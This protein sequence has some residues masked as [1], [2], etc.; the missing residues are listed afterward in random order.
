[1]KGQRLRNYWYNVYKTGLEL[2]G[3]AVKELKKPT[4]KSLEK[5]RNILKKAKKQY[6]QEY[7]EKAPTIR[8]AYNIVTKRK[9]EQADYRDTPRDIETNRTET[10]TNMSDHSADVIQTYLDM[11]DAIYEDTKNYIDTHIQEGETHESGRLAALANQP[12]NRIDLYNTYTRLK[13]KVYRMQSIYGVDALAE[14][15]EESPHLDYAIAITV[16]PPSG[17]KVE[18]EMTI[19]WLDALADKLDTRARELAEQAEEQYYKGE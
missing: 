12:Q 9:Q 3:I 2:Y 7:N 19:E 16:A 17:V 1:M 14:A 11:I 13:E 4:K 5:V 15:I 8:E 10:A 6:E 18:F